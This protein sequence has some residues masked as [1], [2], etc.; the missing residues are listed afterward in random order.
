MNA[1]QPAPRPGAKGRFPWL[2]CGCLLLVIFVLACV[3]FP[4]FVPNLLAQGQAG[5]AADAYLNSIKADKHIQSWTLTSPT[6]GQWYGDGLS[7]GDEA[8][9]SG[10]VTYE[11]GRRDPLTIVLRD[12]GFMN[13]LHENWHV[14]RLD[15]GTGP[16]FTPTP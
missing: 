8:N 1:D 14:A 15:L 12:E 10:E 7:G 11:D 9:I 13:F 4:N 6:I 16:V 3:I 2:T 5:Q